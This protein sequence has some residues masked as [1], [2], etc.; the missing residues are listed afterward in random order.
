MEKTIKKQETELALNTQFTQ[1]NIP[2]FLAQVEEKIKELTKG[3]TDKVVIQ[4]P[5]PGFGLITSNESVSTLVQALAT[6]DA[7]ELNFKNTLEKYKID[8]KSS[9]IIAGHN[10][11][12]WRNEI[13]SR[14]TEVSHKKELD[15]LRSIKKTLEE[16]LSAEAKL[17]NDL[18]NIANLLS[19]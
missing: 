5:F 4:V 19:E 1:A 17:A 6:L 12:N 11:V 8:S 3:T 14:I 9:L 10:V 18:K 16:N 15:K 2:A 7:K 13:L